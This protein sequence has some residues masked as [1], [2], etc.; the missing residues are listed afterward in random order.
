MKLI[1]LGVT[2]LLTLGLFAQ[3]L[4]A[5]LYAKIITNKGDILIELEYLKTP[6]TVAN[7]VGLAE[8]NLTYDSVKI[9]KPYYDGIKF[10]RVIADFMIQGGDPTGTGSGGPGYSFPDEFDTT[11]IHDR[12]GILSMANSGPNT[13]GSQ[14]FITH[15][16]TPWLNGKHSVFGHVVQ[17]QDV[18]N[19]IQQEDMIKTVEIIR[20]GKK[21]QKFNA[22][23]VFP[24]SIEG[25][26]KAKRAELALQN[27]AFSAEMKS[28]YPKAKK[29]DSGLMYQILKQGNDTLAISGDEVEVHYTGTFLS[30]EKFD[31]SR[32]KNKTFK[33]VIDKSRVITGWHEG[34]KLCEIGGEIKLI[35]PYWLAYGEAGR[36]T[37]PPKATLIF[38]IEIISVTKK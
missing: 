34:L 1:T 12:P 36:G 14:F 8:G 25:Q 10:H 38:D 11:L 19:K 33:V 37:I 3:D 20:V 15:K 6:I 22:T 17:G 13:N 7:F 30:G 31:S 4:K 28:K 35:L 18:V 16:D 29:T 21:A 2:F 9:K 24:K 32:D 23:K 27:K 26:A 5:G